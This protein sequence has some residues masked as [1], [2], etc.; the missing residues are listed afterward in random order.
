MKVLLL[1]AHSTTD[2]LTVFLILC[3]L[4]SNHT[5]GRNYNVSASAAE[6]NASIGPLQPTCASPYL[7]R[8]QQPKTSKSLSYEE[9]AD[10]NI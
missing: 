6:P 7:T 2:K 1:L 8:W 3:S 10:Y 4:D 9:L 5:L